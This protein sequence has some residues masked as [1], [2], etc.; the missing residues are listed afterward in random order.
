MEAYHDAWVSNDPVKVAA[1]FTADAVSCSGSTATGAE[2]IANG[3]S[4]QRRAERLT[5]AG[6]DLDDVA[7][8]GPRPGHAA[9]RERSNAHERPVLV[10]RDDVDGEPHADRVNRATTSEHQGM[11]GVERVAAEETLGTLRV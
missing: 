9:R 4:V 5:A 2:S 6:G 7:S 8:P 1:L 11:R 10:E 3:S